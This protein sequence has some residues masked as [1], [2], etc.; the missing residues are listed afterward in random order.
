MLKLLSFC[1]NYVGKIDPQVGSATPFPELEW[2]WWNFSSNLDNINKNQNCESRNRKHFSLVSTIVSYRKLNPPSPI[3]SPPFSDR[4]WGNSF[5]CRL[6]IILHSREKSKIISGHNRKK[7]RFTTRRRNLKGSIF[8]KD[9]ENLS[10]KQNLLKHTK[11]N[12]SKKALF[13]V[14]FNWHS[15]ISWHTKQRIIIPVFFQ[16]K[17]NEKWKN[18]LLL[19]LS[20]IM[21]NNFCVTLR[22]LI[23]SKLINNIISIC[24]M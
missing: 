4:S 24:K 2:W 19:C 8:L 12:C 3:T 14:F 16:K 5:A 18:S 13:N 20:L 9:F 22:P 10:D 17:W 11:T 21:F 15:R 1:A 23:S 6:F 7:L